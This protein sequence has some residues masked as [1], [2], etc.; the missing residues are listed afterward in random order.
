MK[1]PANRY[2]A[3]VL[4]WMA[5]ASTTV[6]GQ[7]IITHTTTTDNTKGHITTIDNAATNGNPKAVL[8]VTQQFG[9]YNTNETGVW[10]SGGK[11][12]IFN[13]NRSAMPI[14]NAFNIVVLDPAAQK[15]A[16]VHSTSGSNTRG[17][18][19]TLNHPATNG[20]PDAVLFVTQHFGKY[21]T[22]PVGVW[23]NGGRWKIYNENKSTLTSDTRFNVLALKPGSLPAGW[24]I[25]GSV[26]QHRV[27]PANKSQFRT[28]HV[29]RIDNPTVNK[30]E[31]IELFSTQ[32]YKGAYNTSIT[33]VWFDKLS[34]TVFNQDRKPLPDNVYFNLLSIN[35][36]PVKLSGNL[37][38]R[39]NT[40]VLWNNSIKPRPD[41]KA[42]AKV[43]ASRVFVLPYAS[44][45]KGSTDN[46]TNTDIMGPD[47]GVGK[48]I[49]T[50]FGSG[51]DRFVEKLNIFRE[52]YEDKNRNSGYFYYLPKNYNLKWDR[53][54]GDYSFYIYYLSADEDGRGDVIV[55]AE[56]TPNI[57]KD[58]I[59]LAEALLTKNM[60]K[61]IKLRPLPLRDTPKVSFGNALSNFDVPDD[62]ISTNIPT[63]F[64]EP[65]VVSWRMDRR[66]DDFIGAMMNNI[67]ISGSIDFLPHGEE[68]RTITVPVKLKVND[69]ATFGAM[70]YTAAASLLNGF[71][72]PIDYPVML[73][74]VIVLREKAKGTYTIQS[75]ALN[76]YQ[77]APGAIFS[78][79]TQSE[80]DAILNG[81]IISR[82]WMDYSVRSCDSCNQ[83]VQSKILGG[84]SGTRVRKI[85]IEV[86]QPL[87]YA[88]ANSL[89]VLIQSRQGDPNGEQSVL[90]PVVN[91]SE[92]NTTI[93]GGEL[94]IAE[95][96]TPE[97]D[98]QLVLINPDGETLISDWVRSENLFVILGESTI[99]EHFETDESETTG[100]VT[101]SDTEITD[102]PVT[103][104]N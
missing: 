75:V 72:N 83:A 88:G 58:D 55:T 100:D 30:N 89:K 65:V 76:N 5:L 4:I 59:A 54:T 102:G 62:R 99:R 18:I 37:V 103:D 56:L 7:Q 61:E 42:A 70:E 63:D 31:N 12:K 53:E 23:Y 94:F 51:F 24:K 82:M 21:N 26:F 73:Q 85:D 20:K 1:H 90:L 41:W 8:I 86:L 78:S 74:E 77:V 19:T 45:S 13:E 84:T 29:S 32:V 80:K 68:E 25:T 97:F 27:T 35:T 16:F 57:D 17:H 64:L 34:W 9:V 22:S 10:Y 92:D 91:I 52:L 66:V 39:G 95:G 101:T 28:Q 44:E 36:R 46:T 3:F 47:S 96:A 49:V 11:W 60:G 2:L 104:G 15:E 69:D 40:K 48:D 50:L 71:Q 6:Y 98:Y 87:A 43:N 81:D 38:V 14:R 79:F 93:S 67:G 33:G